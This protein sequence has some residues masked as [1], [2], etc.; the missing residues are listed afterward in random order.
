MSEVIEG[1]AEK[2]QRRPK[3]QRQWIRRRRENETS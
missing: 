3:P 2:F 1:C